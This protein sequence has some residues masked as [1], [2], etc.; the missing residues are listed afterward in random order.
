LKI[1]VNG[2]RPIGLFSEKRLPS[3]VFGR[4]PCPIDHQDFVRYLLSF[5]LDAEPFLKDREK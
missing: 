3:S 5:Q 1:D 2:P 4:L